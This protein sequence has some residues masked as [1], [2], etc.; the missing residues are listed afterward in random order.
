M[1]W[2]K[3][4]LEEASLLLWS[5]V[6]KSHFDF[7]ILA[8]LCLQI[9]QSFAIKYIIVIYL[10]SIQLKT[11]LL[12]QCPALHQYDLYYASICNML[13]EGLKKLPPHSK[14]N[15]SFNLPS[16]RNPAVYHRPVQT[17]TEPES[18]AFHVS[19][20]INCHFKCFSA[21]SYGNGTWCEVG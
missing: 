20:F 3:K 2:C 13:M 19:K 5:F 8:G 1:K 16:P 17:S 21:P 10:N 15:S 12:L 11:K 9:L 7:R 6:T 4:K 18:T 14:C